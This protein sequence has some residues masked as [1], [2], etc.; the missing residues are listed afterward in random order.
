MG[1]FVTLYGPYAALIL[2][3]LSWAGKNIWPVLVK[4]EEADRAER[5]E[6]RNQL[7]SLIKDN[8]SVIAEVKEVIRHNTYVVETLSRDVSHLYTTLNLSRPE[9]PDEDGLILP[10]SAQK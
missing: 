8:I 9:R 5:R 7:V 3:F 4:R 6:E 2:V 10:P 1:E